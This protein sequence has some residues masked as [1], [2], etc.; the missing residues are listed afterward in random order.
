MHYF[1]DHQTDEL[2]ITRGDFATYGSSYE[3]APGVVLHVSGRKQPLALQLSNARGRVDV[4]GLV[5]FE[6]RPIAPDELAKRMA[7][8]DLGRRSWR[9]LTAPMHLVSGS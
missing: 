6:Q 1:Y 9:A 2:S 8:S 5:S 3:L 7:A 4:S